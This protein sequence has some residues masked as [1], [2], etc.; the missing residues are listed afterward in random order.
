MEAQEFPS[1]EVLVD[2]PEDL[3]P[4]DRE[5]VQNWRTLSPELQAMVP[6]VAQLIVE[7]MGGERTWWDMTEAERNIMGYSLIV[8]SLVD[9]QSCHVSL[10]CGRESKIKVRPSRE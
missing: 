5:R 9:F 2:S 3:G 1:I 8:Q 7:G 10:R 6:H 4:V